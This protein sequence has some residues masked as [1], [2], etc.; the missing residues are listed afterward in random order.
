MQSKTI[1]CTVFE[2][3]YHK[4]G[5][6][7]INSLY[8]N[9]YEGVIWIGYKGILPPWAVIDA[10]GDG[11]DMMKVRDNLHLHFMRFPPTAFLPYCKPLF[12][13]DLFEKY[14]PNAERLFYIDCDIIIKCAFSYFVEWSKFGIAL[15]ED[16]SSP[17]SPSHP[18]R[19]QWAEYFKKYGISVRQN[20]NQYVNGGFI[21]LE[22]SARG[23][24]REWQHIQQLMLEDLKEVNSVGLKDRSYMFNRTDQDALN[25]TKDTTNERLSIAGSDA[26]D[27]SSFG[28]IMSHA[29]GLSKPW[30]NKWLKQVIQKGQRPAMT[31]KLFMNHTES[32]INIYSN[33]DRFFKKIHLKIAT[34]AARVLT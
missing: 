28:F 23:F 16:M 3:H 27:F 17:L 1:V 21:G 20:D 34:A 22:R 29:A 18:L 10:K 25:V 12:L 9:G 19:H 4:G 26:M 2:G 24:L 11:F 33:R 6:A 15:C 8:A 30:E 5:A 7:L 13:L 31:D 32:P 14:A